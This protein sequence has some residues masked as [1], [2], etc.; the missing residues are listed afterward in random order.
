M[1]KVDICTVSSVLSSL[2]PENGML[3]IS[4]KL[5]GFFCLFESYSRPR[6]A[7]AGFIGTDRSLPTGHDALL[8]HKIARNISHELS[9]IH[10]NTCHGH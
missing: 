1:T 9:H 7:H 6:S 3:D 2:L 8:L 10:D 4:C 5:Y